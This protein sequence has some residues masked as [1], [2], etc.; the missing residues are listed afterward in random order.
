MISF[1]KPAANKAAIEESRFGGSSSSSHNLGI[2][3]GSEDIDDNILRAVSSE[4]LSLP[5][6]TSSEKSSEST[7]TESSGPGTVFE[8]I[9]HQG[10]SLVGNIS[11]KYKSSPRPSKD[12]VQP[13]FVALFALLAI[14]VQLG[15]WN[16]LGYT[17]LGLVSLFLSSFS[18]LFQAYTTNTMYNDIKENKKNIRVNK[19]N[20]LVNKKNIKLVLKKVDRLIDASAAILKL[21]GQPDDE[22]KELLP[23]DDDKEALESA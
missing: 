12:I 22:I 3:T 23:E 19:K 9:V 2:F 20:I 21:L 13:V 10:T 14:V 4:S 16:L 1:F 11:K 15:D 5:S 6:P 8:K 7:L 18:Y 17:V